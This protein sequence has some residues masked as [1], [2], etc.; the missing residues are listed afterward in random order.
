MQI[1]NLL[2]TVVFASVALV[3]VA[4]EHSLRVVVPLDEPGAPVEPAHMEQSTD[5]MKPP[6]KEPAASVDPATLPVGLAA[7]PLVPLAPAQAGSCGLY[8]GCVAANVTGQCCPVS[9]IQDEKQQGI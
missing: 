2:F 5:P 3:P 4:A 6:P 8:P 7:P 9:S 1:V